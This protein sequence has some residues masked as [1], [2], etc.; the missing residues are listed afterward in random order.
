MSAAEPRDDTDCRPRRARFVETTF[1]ALAWCCVVLL[2][3][4]S[5][6]PAQDMVRSG[7]PGQLEHFFAYAGSAA[8]GMVG[9]GRNRGASRIVTGLW[10][11]AGLLE[12]LQRFSTGRHSSLEDFAASAFGALCGALFV[13]FVGRRR[14]L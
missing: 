11:Y 5:L 2:V 13:S 10:I 12:Y 9:Y 3:V 14:L 4:L 6:V 7:L 1:R 8:V